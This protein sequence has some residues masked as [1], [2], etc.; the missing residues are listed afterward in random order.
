MIDSILNIISVSK[1]QLYD[2]NAAF[3]VSL[4]EKVYINKDSSLLKEVYSFKNIDDTSATAVGTYWFTNK[5][6]NYDFS[7]SKEL[8]SINKMKLYKVRY[9]S[10]PRHFKN[11]FILDQIELS[12][13]LLEIN[14][15][16]EKELIYFFNRDKMQNVKK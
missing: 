5:L 12:F 9:I 8:D 11:N 16:N 10:Y 1:I 4:I 15:D 2:K 7:L 13:D 3:N 6:K 14:I